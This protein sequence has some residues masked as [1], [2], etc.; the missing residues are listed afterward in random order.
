MTPL[1]QAALSVDTWFDD[2]HAV[3][4]VAGELDVYTYPRLRD[5]LVRLHEAG[6]HRLVL[7]LQEL[8]FTDSSGLG[9]LVGAVKRA[10]A[11]G[12]GLVLVGVRESILRVLRITG[13]VRVMPPFSEM[14]EAFVH[15]DAQ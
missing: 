8:E 2:G 1:G 4:V 13:L 6:H 7:D 14:A 11:S 3:V 15:L 5:E 12:G 10:R 9:V